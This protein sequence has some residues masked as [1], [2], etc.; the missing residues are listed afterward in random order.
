MVIFTPLPDFHCP[1]EL[2]EK[3]NTAELMRECH[4]TQREQPIRAVT[5]GIGEA[6]GATY[7]KGDRGTPVS[8]CSQC[9]CK[10][11]R[12]HRCTTFIEY[13]YF[14]LSFLHR[15]EESLRLLG[16]LFAGITLL[17]RGN[18]YDLEAHAVLESSN[19]F[20]A[21]S[22][23]PTGLQR[24]DAEE[25][26]ALHGKRIENRGKRKKCTSANVKSLLVFFFASLHSLLQYRNRLDVRSMRK[27]VHRLHHPEVVVRLEKRTEISRER[28]RVA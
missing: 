21:S 23:R 8:F 11:F 12:R 1:V 5:H 24:S 9:L 22:T 26:E 13:P 27:E 10:V 14:P 16:G 3:E 6:I 28:C 17:A 7:D 2:L 15:R 4:Q 20:R 25:T 18:L 19:E